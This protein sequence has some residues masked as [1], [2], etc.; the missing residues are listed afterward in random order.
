MLERARRF[1]SSV[2]VG[3]LMLGT[4]GL[5]TTT[6]TG[7]EKAAAATND[8]A[9]PAEPTE[10]ETVAAAVAVGVPGASGTI[11]APHFTAR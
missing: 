3:L 1:S 2:V 11:A 7:C 5:A 9:Q 8:G 4:A 6:L 10:V